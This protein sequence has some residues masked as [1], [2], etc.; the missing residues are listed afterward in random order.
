MDDSETVRIDAYAG[1]PKNPLLPP[2]G[3]KRLIEEAQDYLNAA[4]RAIADLGRVHDA[5][6]SA[7]I[8]QEKYIDTISSL[9]VLLDDKMHWAYEALRESPEPKS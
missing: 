1:E 4:Q 8:D 2:G 9:L 3:A 5:G 7:L 6:A